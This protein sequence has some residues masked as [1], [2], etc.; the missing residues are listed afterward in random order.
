MVGRAREALPQLFGL[1]PEQWDPPGMFALLR[2]ASPITYVTAD[3][4]PVLM[5]HQGPH[6]DLPEGLQWKTADA[7]SLHYGQLLGERISAVG[8]RAE[9][10]LQPAGQSSPAW[11]ERAL[12][13]LQDVLQ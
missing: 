11:V 7:H 2:E 6:R 13:F 10:L 5:I 12:A 3:D 1:T 8:G 4:P 9:L